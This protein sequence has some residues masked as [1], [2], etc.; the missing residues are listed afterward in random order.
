[1]C[2]TGTFSLLHCGCRHMLG[3]M[4]WDVPTYPTC[5]APALLVWEG[6]NVPLDTFISI[7]VV[8]QR[9]TLK[10]ASVGRYRGW[11]QADHIGN[12]PM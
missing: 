1:M 11:W 6:S 2:L 7:T 5:S 8:S 10:V 3:I 9:A 12:A 4:Y